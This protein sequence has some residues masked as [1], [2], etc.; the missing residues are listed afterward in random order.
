MTKNLL[1]RNIDRRLEFCN[2]VTVIIEMTFRSR[3]LCNEAG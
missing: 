2:Y 1:L 3:K